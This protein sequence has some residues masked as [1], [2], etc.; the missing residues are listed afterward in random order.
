MRASQPIAVR[1]SELTPPLTDYLGLFTHPAYLKV[2]VSLS[3][4]DT[5]IAY[6]FG[7]ALPCAL[8]RPTSSSGAAAGIGGS[9]G[10]GAYAYAVP[11]DR[12]VCE[13]FGNS[14]TLTFQRTVTDS[15]VVAVSVVWVEDE[16][17]LPVAIYRPLF[18]N[19]YYRAAVDGS[20]ASNPFTGVSSLGGL[21]VVGAGA[22][23]PAGPP[24]Q[25]GPAGPAGSSGSSA[26]DSALV[27]SLIGV[28]V[29]VAFAAIMLAYALHRHA[30]SVS[31]ISHSLQREQ[32][33]EAK[34]RR[35]PLLH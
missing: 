10:T 12:F 1:Q 25:V 7:R 6:M 14:F 32:Q 29:A 35:E 4:S 30:L 13:Y 2:N 11:D 9:T 27:Y 22:Q 28:A 31:G 34:A 21:P 19:S 20:E 17:G 15:R 24:G 33:D 26:V 18:T 16:D 23:G 5:L 8:R 3:A